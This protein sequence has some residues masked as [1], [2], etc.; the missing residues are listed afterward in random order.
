MRESSKVNF[1]KKRSEKILSK[2]K[3]VFKAP[4]KLVDNVKNKLNKK[5]EIKINL[6]MDKEIYNTFT[7]I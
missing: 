6:F 4:K 1:E 5:D 3:Y 2:K 7:K